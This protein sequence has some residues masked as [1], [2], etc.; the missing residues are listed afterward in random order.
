MP[1]TVLHIR[2]YVVEIYRP[3][4]PLILFIVVTPMENYVRN[5]DPLSRR[6][7]RAR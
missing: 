4:N 7:F 6:R 5:S 2:I 3:F 1:I